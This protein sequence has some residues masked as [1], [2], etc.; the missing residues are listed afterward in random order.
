MIVE[1]KKSFE[2]FFTSIRG[3]IFH[4]TKLKHVFKPVEIVD[5]YRLKSVFLKKADYFA[6]KRSTSLKRRAMSAINCALS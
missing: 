4:D 1:I 3:R 5:L 6:A 2:D